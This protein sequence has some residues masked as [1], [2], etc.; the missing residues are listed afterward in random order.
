MNPILAIRDKL[1]SFSNVLEIS[2]RDEM[3]KHRKFIV[4][5][6]KEQLMKG[7]KGDGTDM[8]NYVPNSKQP[9]AQGKITLF[10]KGDFHSGID[11]LFGEEGFDLVGLDEKTWFLVKRYG[12]ILNLTDESK[13]KL[14]ERL[15]PSLLKRILKLIK[16][17]L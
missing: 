15:R 13:Q 10:D 17:K 8:P 3:I 2:V 11:A 6:N 14:R 9:S 4:E 1:L 7:Q 5:L 16:Q 12:N